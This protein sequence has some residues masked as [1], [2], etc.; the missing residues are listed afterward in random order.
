MNRYAKAMCDIR[1]LPPPTERE[2]Q[3]QRFSYA[4]GNLA[5]STNHKP[6]LAAF[7]AMAKSEGWTPEEFTDWAK[8]L[9]WWER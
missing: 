4:Y 8:D 9:E 5:C 6:T 7:A 2:K 3:I 1:K